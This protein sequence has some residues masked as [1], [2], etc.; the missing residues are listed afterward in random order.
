MSYHMV[1]CKKF[2]GPEGPFFL[3]V[4]MTVEDLRF[5]VKRHRLCALLGA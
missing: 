5:S 4:L 2:Y 3:N 1:N